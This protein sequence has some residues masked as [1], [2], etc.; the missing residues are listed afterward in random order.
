LQQAVVAW[1]VFTIRFEGRSR[2][3][4]RMLVHVLITWGG[5]SRLYNTEG[6]IISA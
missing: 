3:M 4:T 5:K 1:R 6:P 2:K